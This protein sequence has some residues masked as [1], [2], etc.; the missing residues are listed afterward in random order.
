H[1]PWRAGKAVNV[2]PRRPAGWRRAR[3]AARFAG[4]IAMSILASL[5]RA[6][7][8]LPDVPQPG[9]STE[10][11]GFLIS[12]N[13][14]GTVAAVADLRQGDGRKKVPRMMQVPQPVK[15]TAAV[16]PNTLWD[17]TSYVLGVTAG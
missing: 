12:L 16:A 1:R 9:Y 14:D 5:A 13:D 17:K 8:R 7:D 10:K 2:F 11:I 3:A 4:G 15:R 6:Y